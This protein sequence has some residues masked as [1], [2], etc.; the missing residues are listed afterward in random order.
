MLKDSMEKFKDH[1]TNVSKIAVVH[2]DEKDKIGGTNANFSKHFGL[3]RVGV[4]Y[5][6][7]PSGY[8]TSQPHSES[9]EEEFVFVIEGEIDLWFNGKIKAMKKGDC[10]GFP[11]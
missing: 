5:F 6:K 7:I 9:L 3:N 11:L 4:H 2:F 10:V 8:R 1:F